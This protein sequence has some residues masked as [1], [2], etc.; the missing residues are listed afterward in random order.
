V[1]SLY[2]CAMYV[3]L[4]CVG[5]LVTVFVFIIFWTYSDTPVVKASGRELSYLLLVGTLAS[6]CLTFVIV[7]H[8]TPLTCGLTRFFLGFCYTL[9]YAAIVTKTNRIARIFNN[10]PMSPHKTRYFLFLNTTYV[11]SDLVIIIHRLGC[12][13]LF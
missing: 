3:L 6:F 11:F 13:S 8:P 4:L 9:C 2:D 12:F 1:L 7:A 5:I 10:R